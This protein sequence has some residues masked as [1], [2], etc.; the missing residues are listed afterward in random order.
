[1]NSSGYHSVVTQ[2]QQRLKEVDKDPST[3]SL[4][5]WEI[6]TS[7]DTIRTYLSEGEEERQQ[8]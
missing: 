1:M 3:I 4:L 6:G 8:A 2:T 5:K 7:Y